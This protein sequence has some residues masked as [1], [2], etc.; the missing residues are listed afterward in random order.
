MKTTYIDSKEF[1]ESAKLN[2]GRRILNGEVEGW[3]L[4]AIELG[5]PD[6]LAGIMRTTYFVRFDKIFPV[7]YDRECLEEAMNEVSEGD[8]IIVND[9]ILFKK[10]EDA[11]AAYLRFA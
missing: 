10:K 1:E 9:Q 2:A 7:G 4:Q 5:E 3:T 6:V 8:C 11:V